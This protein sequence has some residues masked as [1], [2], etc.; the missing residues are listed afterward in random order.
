MTLSTIFM[1]IFRPIITP[2]AKF[3]QGGKSRRLRKSIKSKRYR[4]SRTRRMK[5]G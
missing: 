2:F 4:R 3:M 5:G 1:P